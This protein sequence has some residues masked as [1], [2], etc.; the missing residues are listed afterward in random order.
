[1]PP[2]K[3]KVAGAAA[4]A[5]TQP[6]KKARTGDAAVFDDESHASNPSGRPKRSTS[7]E[8]PQYNFTRRHNTTATQ[9]GDKSAQGSTAAV[10]PKATSEVP[11]RGRGRPP[12]V[13]PPVVEE[14]AP[15]VMKRGRG[16]PPK[17]SS[18]STGDLAPA[19]PTKKG[20]LKNGTGAANKPPTTRPNIRAPGGSTASAAKRRASATASPPAKKQIGRPAKK[21]RGRPSTKTESTDEAGHTIVSLAPEVNGFQ[22]DDEAIDENMQY[23]LMKAEPESRIEKGR[24][25]K[26]SIGDLAVRTEPEGWDGKHSSSALS[27]SSL[28]DNRRCPQSSCPQHH[29]SHAS[30]R[31]SLLLSLQLQDP[32]R[33]WRHAH[34][35]R[36]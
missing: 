23:W 11:K 28:T 31:L 25:V 10:T 34:R 35:G 27:E 30:W 4:S 24:D 20:I 26:F 29:A 14:S 1:M 9:N 8:E 5:S 15:A 7:N 33:C 21:K 13:S 6:A 17:V 19:T 36:A 18:N 22:N 12:K 2:K 16:R 32:W 3:R